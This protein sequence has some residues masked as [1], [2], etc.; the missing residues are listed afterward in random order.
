MFEK[1]EVPNH[2]ENYSL[3][4]LKLGAVIVTPEISS[5]NGTRAKYLEHGNQ[6]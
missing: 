4:R 2:A 3:L 1:L 5:S 6:T